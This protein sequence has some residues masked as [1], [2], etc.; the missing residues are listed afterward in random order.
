MKNRDY[1]EF[2]ENEIYHIYNRGV[3]KMDIFKDQQDFNVFLL[4]LKENIYPNLLK[5]TETEIS[6]K[7]RK[8]LPPHS[9]NLIAYCLMPNHFHLLIQQTNKTPASKLLS[10]LCTSYAMY[11]NRK[12]K[13]VGGLFQDQFKAVLIKNNAQLLWTSFYIHKNPLE[14]KITYDLKDYKWNSY[15]E[16]A[17]LVEEDLCKK[18]ILIKQFNPQYDFID[19]FNKTLKSKKSSH[20]MLEFYD[21]F[22]DIE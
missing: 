5:N 16:Y 15:L 17:G 12:Y 10:K 1:K 21:L 18:N 7:K 3:A 19:D 13:R 8:R 20:K 9:F 2:A 4:R 22:I 6:D 11:F 14:A